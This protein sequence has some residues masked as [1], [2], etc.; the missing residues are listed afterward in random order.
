MSK[1][2]PV[3]HLSPFERRALALVART[4]ETTLGKRLQSGWLDRAVYPLVRG[5]ISRRTYVVGA[6]WMRG[7]RPDRGVLLAA[8]HRSF[9]DQWLLMLTLW[10]AELKFF[11]KIYFPVRSNYF[12]ET[13]AGVFVN[14]LMGGGSLYPPIFRDRE[15]AEFNKY[16]LERVIEFLGDPAALVGV[17][18][19]GTRGKGPDPYELLPAQPG[20][21]QMILQGHPIVVPAFVNGLSNDAIGNVRANFRRGIR[22]DDPIIMVFGEPFD[23][24]ELAAQKPRAALYKKCAD[25]VLQRI[26]ELGEREREL[27]AQCAAGAIGDDD[28]GWLYNRPGR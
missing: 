16:A 14:Y 12:Y 7:W 18:P 4:N 3:E 2:P 15:K 26:R 21:G 11:D 19:E 20:V 22:Q 24:S 27:R 13:K 8:N 10:T 25:Q 17:H 1:R 23:Y 28:P 6:D 9:F 5:G